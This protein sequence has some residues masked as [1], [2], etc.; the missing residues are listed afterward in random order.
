[1]MKS[2]N[3]SNKVFSTKTNDFLS[4]FDKIS[5]ERVKNFKYDFEIKLDGENLQ[6]KIK[7]DSIQKNIVEEF[8]RKNGFD[9]E[10]IELIV[11]KKE[12]KKKVKKITLEEI[13]S[14]IIF[15]KKDIVFRNVKIST[16]EDIHRMKSQLSI[17]ES[18]NSDN[19]VIPQNFV[20]L[21]IGAEKHPSGLEWQKTTRTTMCDKMILLHNEG[22]FP[23]PYNFGLL[24]GEESNVC[25]LDIDVKN[26]GLEDWAEFIDAVLKVEPKT[27]KVI[28]GSGGLHYYFLFEEKLG[29]LTRIKDDDGEQLSW[30][31]K[32]TSG[33]VLFP[34]SIHPRTGNKYVHSGDI[35]NDS[36]IYKWLE[37]EYSSRNNGKCMCN[38]IRD[39]YIKNHTKE[40]N[41]IPDSL[42][43]FLLKHKKPKITS[44]I[45]SD[46][47]TKYNNP[48]IECVCEIISNLSTERATN[49]ETWWRVVTSAS[50]VSINLKDKEHHIFDAVHYFSSKAENY[51]CESVNTQWKNP[52][53][54][55][56]ENGGTN[57]FFKW[58]GEDNMEKRDEINAKYNLVKNEVIEHNLVK[59]EDIAHDLIKHENNSYDVYD[60]DFYFGTFIDWANGRHFSMHENADELISN[61]L[62]KCVRWVRGAK[63]MY[64]VKCKD[65]VFDT[66]DRD[67]TFPYKNV[68]YYKFVEVEDK[69]TKIKS[70]EEKACRIFSP[71]KNNICLFSDDCCVWK[72]FH[73]HEPLE[74]QI[75]EF[76][77]FPGFKARK[78]DNFNNKHMELIQP[79]LNHIKNVW[80]AGNEE[81]YKFIL[82][83]FAHP[84]RTL[85]KC[86]KV[87][88]IHGEPGVGKSIIF[89][90]F[91]E[92][93]YGKEISSQAG[94]NKFTTK[95]NSSIINKMF[96][97]MHELCDLDMFSETVK[98]Q[99]ENLKTAVTEDLISGE[100]KGFDVKEFPNYGN[101]CGCSNNDV[102]VKIDNDNDRR[103]AL[104][105]CNNKFLPKSKDGKEKIKE[106]SDL[107]VSVNNKSISCD[108]KIDTKLVA[109]SLYTYLLYG[110][111]EFLNMTNAV[112]PKTDLRK[113]SIKRSQS[114]VENFLEAL[115]D[116]EIM[117]HKKDVYVK[118]F[119]AYNVGENKKDVLF[120]RST[121]LYSIFC[122]WYTKTHNS[123][124][125][126]FFD[127]TFYEGIFKKGSDYFQRQ[128]TTIGNDRL[129]VRGFAIIEKESGNI[130]IDMQDPYSNVCVI[131][132]YKTISEYIEL[133]K[134]KK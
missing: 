102:S 131:D 80:C 5:D 65:N 11:E 106:L 4:L 92:H 2:D 27:F 46:I 86:Q 89:N 61:K 32:S 123:N 112:I 52:N 64:Y 58:L 45:P 44:K 13:E 83:W 105:E 126:N 116:N 12:V 74:K 49:F 118:N 76:N 68:F 79:I 101:F 130:K 91:A 107:L 16:D 132:R 9:D 7:E 30:D 57:I 93:I 25:V 34:G 37:K 72:P 53:K 26:N 20:L 42:L 39:L 128:K 1:M 6:K 19:Y 41:K 85:T 60:E 90:F 82:S 29:N 63:G 103:F 43:N 78:I 108:K 54:K 88:I 47:S 71:L 98:Q 8:V 125:K 40:I 114:T 97:V 75:K 120:V 87:L 110:E 113:R 94:F 66:N 119:R 67:I 121:T 14:S 117:I 100:K 15:C 99:F 10:D 111:F 21:T 38:N 129:Q 70:F 36:S 18:I 56:D 69:K 124:T 77:I 84:L 127:K 28:T 73:K 31:F 134:I 81:Y 95:F 3:E 23:Y 24:C 22:L 50:A 51:D 96:L 55:F 17:F 35:L 33:Q 115:K 122:E 62:A 59:L 48:D 133:S 104:F 109:D